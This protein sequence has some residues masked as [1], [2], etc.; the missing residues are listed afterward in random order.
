MIAKQQSAKDA[1]LSAKRQELAAGVLKQA[2]QDLRRFYGARNRVERELYYDAYTWVMSED[3]LWPFSFL[4]VC[5]AL[6]LASDTVRYDLMSDLSSGTFRY[7][8]RRCARAAR[9]CAL[10]F[11]RFIGTERVTEASDP[12]LTNPAAT[13]AI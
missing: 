13:S 6:N 12:V 4:N 10:S 9:R 5:D 7:L 2:A 8:T 11:G 1:D 3:D